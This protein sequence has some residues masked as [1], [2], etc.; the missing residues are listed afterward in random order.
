MKLLILSPPR[1]G[2]SNLLY[3]IAEQGFEKISEPYNI[4]L[5]KN[6][7]KWPLRWNSYKTHIV[8]KHL[9]FSDN[10]NYQQVPNIDTE[11]SIS[12]FAKEFDK[13]IL[14]DRKDY[15]S[16]LESFINLHYRTRYDSHIKYKYEDIPAEYISNFLENNNQL[17]LIEGKE[18]CKKLSIILNTPITWYEELYG[19]N[20]E[21]SLEIIKE[22]DISNIDCNLLNKKLNPMFRYRQFSTTKII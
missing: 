14:L 18:L 21:R 6:R 8:V 4:F 5:H 19:D 15:K 10:S 16:H 20:R 11:F 1:T 9:I 2:T 12:L 3:K 17:H 13:I 22:W 7:Y